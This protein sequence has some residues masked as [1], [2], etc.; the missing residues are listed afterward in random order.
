MI[1]TA[2]PTADTALTFIDELG[3]FLGLPSGE[4]I[5]L[6]LLV[7][8]SLALIAALLTG[9]LLPVLSIARFAYPIAHVKATGTPFV[10]SGIVDSLT[11]SRHP[12]EVLNAV[13]RQGVDLTG[14]QPSDPVSLRAG[15]RAWQQSEFF[16]LQASVP[17]G[18]QP[19]FRALALEPEIGALKGVIVRKHRGIPPDDIETA[20]PPVGTIDPA[21]LR[22]LAAAP[23]MEDLVER[24]GRTPYGG[25][26]EE[27]LPRYRAENQ[28]FPLTVALDR[29]FFRELSLSVQRSDRSLRA[30]IGAYAGTRID[31]ANLL[32]VLSGK[33]SGHCRERIQEY[34]VPGGRALP[35]DLL[36]HMAEAPTL[37]ESMAFLDRT[38]YWEVLAPEVR[39]FEA[40]PDVRGILAALD[41]F[42]LEYAASLGA[43]DPLQ[44]GPILEFLT[45]LEYEARNL[46]VVLTGVA[47]G[48]PAGR[49]QPLLVTRGD[50]L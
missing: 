26:L 48:M 33:A 37:L 23:T 16:A 8:V 15:I 17:R 5:V 10:E 27:A 18:I 22:Q 49:M 19:F 42:F 29:Y 2:P 25:V 6:L 36:E 32:A 7:A 34:L 12:D 31:I 9:A 46:H 20:V 35:L 3:G 28:V 39:G 4:V 44:A 24:L 43:T 1:P 21:L 50:R 13:Q 41:R 30:T 47:R 11:G 38:A 14:I 40:D 45:A